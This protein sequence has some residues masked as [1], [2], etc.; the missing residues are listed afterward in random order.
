MGTGLRVERVLGRAGAGDPC[1]LLFGGVHG[2]EPAGVFAL[3]RLF[4]ELGDR[5]LTGTVVALAGNL[6]ALAR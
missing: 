2:N 6:N 1:V 5:K 3:Q 4:Q